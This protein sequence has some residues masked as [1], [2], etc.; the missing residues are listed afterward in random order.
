M[1]PP[2][3]PQS[4]SLFPFFIANGMLTSL[5]L[6]TLAASLVTAAPSYGDP[7]PTQLVSTPSNG[8]GPTSFVSSAW[9]PGWESQKF[10][11]SGVSWQK[12]SLVTYAFAYVFLPVLRSVAKLSAHFHF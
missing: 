6:S 2:S 10:P 1:P 12:Y 3:Y 11:V 7:H 4:C 9:Y 5:F 8:T